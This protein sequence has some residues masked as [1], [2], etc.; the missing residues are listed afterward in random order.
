MEDMTTRIILARH[1]ESVVNVV[2]LASDELEGNPLT[3]LGET[4][5]HQLARASR[6]ESISAVITS[7]VQRARQT[8]EIVAAELGVPV[9]VEWG[10][11]EILVGVHAGEVAPESVVR[12]IADFRIWLLEEDLTHGY[13]GGESGLEVVERCAAALERIAD[14]YPDQTV[15]VV[16][17]GGAIAFTVPTLCDNVT[18]RSVYTRQLTNCA[19]VV[20]ERDN[21]G[22]TCVSWQGAAPATFVGG[23]AAGRHGAHEVLDRESA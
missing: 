14:R 21:D 15:L 13:L 11:E 3:Y 9:R 8:G 5:A 2:G 16:S 23:P 10:L 7:P 6:D 17:H 18:L 4:Q 1:G 22:W 20:V 19:T 12:G